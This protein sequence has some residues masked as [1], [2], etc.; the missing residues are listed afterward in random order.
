[1][2]LI[3]RYLLYIGPLT[4]YLSVKKAMMRNWG[5]WDSNFSAIAYELRKQ[6]VKILDTETRTFE[7]IPVC[8]RHFK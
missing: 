1:M 8:N 4:T 7:C 6:L 3:D 5:N 2:K